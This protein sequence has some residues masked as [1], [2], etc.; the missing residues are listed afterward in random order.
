MRV[1]QNVL[2]NTDQNVSPLTVSYDLGC[3]KVICFVF[4]IGKLDY[5][6]ELLS[7]NLIVTSGISRI[8]EATI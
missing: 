5:L 8:Y 7:Q 2:N 4:C 1:Y 3:S 6:V